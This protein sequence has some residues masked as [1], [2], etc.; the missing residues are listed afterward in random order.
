MEDAFNKEQAP[1]GA[2]SLYSKNYRKISLT[3]LEPSH[4]S[5]TGAGGGKLDPT[6]LCI[7]S[8]KKNIKYQSV[9]FWWIKVLSLFISSAW[10]DLSMLLCVK[11]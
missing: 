10:I 6:S 7:Q 3:A 11:N 4:H 8:T 2:F 1:V 9:P 5:C